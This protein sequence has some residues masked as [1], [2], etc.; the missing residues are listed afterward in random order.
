VRCLQHQQGSYFEF[1]VP[2]S[3]LTSG[4]RLLGKVGKC[5]GVGLGRVGVLT[6]LISHGE[7]KHTMFAMETEN[8]SLWKV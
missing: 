2:A 7:D 3:I 6:L 8:G 4:F 5:L 1:L